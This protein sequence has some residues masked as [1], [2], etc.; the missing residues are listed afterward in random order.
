MLF[1]D[2]ALDAGAERPGVRHAPIAVH[3]RPGRRVVDDAA[4]EHGRA[5]RSRY[6]RHAGLMTASP[7]V[8]PADRIEAS[9]RVRDRPAFT[10]NVPVM[11]GDVT[12]AVS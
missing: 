7:A 5:V 2:L 8:V 4:G 3:D 1:A 12:C 9:G 6:A 11:A 10:G